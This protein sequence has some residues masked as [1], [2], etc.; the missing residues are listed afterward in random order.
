VTRELKLQ[1]SRVSGKASQPNETERMFPAGF[2][3]RFAVA[4]LRAEESGPATVSKKP[5]RAANV[6]PSV[7]GVFKGNAKEAKLARVSAHQRDPFNNQPGMV[8]C[9]LKR[10]IPN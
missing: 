1:D 7:T 8:L 9:S 6:K 2:D 4:L 5:G 10:I 3:V